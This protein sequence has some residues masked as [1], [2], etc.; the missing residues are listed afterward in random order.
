MVRRGFSLESRSQGM[1]IGFREE[2]NPDS[3][4]GH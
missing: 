3:G 2:R 1:K 4:E